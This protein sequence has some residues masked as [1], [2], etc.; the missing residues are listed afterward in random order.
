MFTDRIRPIR[1]SPADSIPSGALTIIGWGGI[2][3]GAGI[4]RKATV[5][6]INLDTCRDAM[7]GLEVVGNIYNDTNFCT[8][9][10]TGQYAACNG[11]DSYDSLCS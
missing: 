7:N 4:L 11:K 2:G 3:L 1:L 6:P 10:M 8:G 9:P 5:F